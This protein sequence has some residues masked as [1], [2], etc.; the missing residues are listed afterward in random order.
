MRF[1]N[2]TF[3]VHVYNL[4]LQIVGAI[5]FSCIEGNYWCWILPAFMLFLIPQAWRQAVVV[6]DDDGV[7]VGGKTRIL[8]TDIES[9]AKRGWTRAV[10][11]LRDGRRKSLSMFDWPTERRDEFYA[12]I[13]KIGL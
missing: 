13:E 6:V 10:F 11:M 2:Q 9:L 5:L 12:L 8:W 3:A 7:K 1:R 4:V